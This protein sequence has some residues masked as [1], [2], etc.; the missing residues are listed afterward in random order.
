[1]PETR[2]DALD[3]AVPAFQ[4]LKA[5]A[6][7]IAGGALLCLLLVVVEAWEANLGKLQHQITYRNKQVF[8]LDSFICSKVS[9]DILSLRRVSF[10][11]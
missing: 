2:S 3:N 6:L 5:W 9:A 4:L 10:D 7:S 8:R 11:L 1:M